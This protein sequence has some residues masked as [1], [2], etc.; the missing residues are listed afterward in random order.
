MSV[1]VLP[2]WTKALSREEAVH[3]E[4][5]PPKKKLDFN[6][7][8]PTNETYYD[9]EHL[10]FAECF[11][12]ARKQ[13][14][15]KYHRNP[16]YSRQQLQDSILSH[17]VNSVQSKDTTK[18]PWIVF[19]AGAMGVGKGYAMSTL[20][21][22]DSFPLHRFIIVDPDKLKNELPEMPGYLKTDPESAAT[23]LHRESTQMTDVLF[24][25][26]LLRSKSLL[27]DGSLRDTDW[28]TKLFKKIRSEYPQYRI[29]ILHVTARRET[30][31]ARA[32]HRA[33]V[34]GRA[35]PPETIEES[36]QQV[37]KSVER[38]APLADVAFNI[39]NED[40]T[41]LELGSA[42]V[43]GKEVAE[44]SWEDF[45]IAW[46]DEGITICPNGKVCT[47]EERG[48]CIGGMMNCWANEKAHDAAKSVWV[49]AYPNFCPRCTLVGDHQC[50]V[51]EHGTHYCAC[52]ECKHYE[53]CPAN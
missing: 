38:L 27:V 17:I 43:K 25:Y 31:H 34:S 20:A 3:Q 11:A 2:D 41:P 13:L 5:W 18:R 51:C 22:T 23:K 49:A 6:W 26:G 32:R 29:G 15:Y 24:E 30:I 50:G 9:P 39:S 28:Y 46:E 1:V 48:L 47:K 36:L 19:T 14:D 33:K 10:D 40:D 45:K 8:L 4:N 42:W 52:D 53:K 44:I 16:V 7:N 12:E 35:V 37:P 21:S